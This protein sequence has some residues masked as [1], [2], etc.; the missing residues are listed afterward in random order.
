MSHI[1][2]RLVMVD[3]VDSAQPCSEWRYMTDLPKL[4]AVRCLTVGWIVAEDN[5]VIMLVQSVGEVETQDTQVSGLMRIPVA[6]VTKIV[7]LSEDD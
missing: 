6:S 1:A 2:P 4:E 5:N 7:K 3:W